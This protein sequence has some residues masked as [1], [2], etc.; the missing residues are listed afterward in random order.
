[1]E[2]S[3]GSLGR[4]WRRFGSDLGRYESHVETELAKIS[5][6]LAKITE[7]LKKQRKR[8]VFWTRRARLGPSWRRLEDSGGRHGR[9]WRHLGSVLG[10]LGGLLETS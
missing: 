10:A 2:A 3:W 8:A 4:C 9:S 7:I 1:M 6:T 5:P